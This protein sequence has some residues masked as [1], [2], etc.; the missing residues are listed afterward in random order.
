MSP[1]YLKRQ[2]VRHD[3]TSNGI[4]ETDN[5]RLLL[6]P[7]Q[8]CQWDFSKTS[9]LILRNSINTTEIR[10][11]QLVAIC[12]SNQQYIFEKKCYFTE[13]TVLNVN[14]NTNRFGLADYLVEDGRPKYLKF[15]RN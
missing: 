3:C 9:N 5:Q 2:N 7:C 10:Q 13:L 12:Y 8:Q 14:M 15:I 4:K 11:K 1:N 6:R